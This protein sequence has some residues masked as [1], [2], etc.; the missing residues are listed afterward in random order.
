MPGGRLKP[1]QGA[2][3]DSKLDSIWAVLQ[4]GGVD[5]VLSGHHHTYERFPRMKATGGKP[6]TGAPDPAGVRQL[7]AGTGGGEQESFVPNMI[8]P[9]SEKRI[10]HNWGSSNWSCT[11]TATTGRSCRQ[12]LLE[13]LNLP[14]APSSIPVTTVAEVQCP[15]SKALVRAGTALAGSAPAPLG[16]GGERPRRFSV[17]RI[18]RVDLFRTGSVGGQT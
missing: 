2:S 8:D 7:I 11:T 3:S 14:P 4:Q 16:R 17:L 18:R 15:A 9:N 1:G 6:G 10:E 12:E 13:R 5:V